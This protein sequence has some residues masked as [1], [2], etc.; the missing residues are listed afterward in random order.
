MWIIMTKKTFVLGSILIF[1]V[2]I[3]S[4]FFMTKGTDIPASTY[5][6]TAGY[7][8]LIIDDFGNFDDGTTEI[9]NLGIPFTAAIMPNLP[10]TEQLAEIIHD[11]GHEII[12]H[13]PM[14]PEYGDPTWL[15]SEAI[16]VNLTDEEIQQRI[17]AGLEQVKWA[18][19]MN[20]HMGSKI[21]KDERIMKRILQI[22]K[23]NQLLFIDS[24][25][26]EESTIPRLATALGV[27][28]FVR[29][30]FL[31]TIK[32]RQAIQNKL[33]ELAD[34]A[35]KQGY[36]IGIGHVGPEGGTVTVEAIRNVQPIL[37]ERGIQFVY[38]SR[39]MEINF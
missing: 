22:A 29:D 35:L 6:A 15:G 13:I 38:L 20:N 27:P 21:T 28:Y 39:L 11:A 8:A 18:I 5:S 32:N 23:D 37:E 30:L 3:S 14:E 24:K 4:L 36:A 2:I 17:I 12:L 31:D 1:I 34:I 16:T 10:Y 25:T 19:G 9:I 33:M 7:I 26:T